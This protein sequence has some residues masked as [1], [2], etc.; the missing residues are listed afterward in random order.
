[1]ARKIP[2]K[3]ILELHAAHMSRN[4]IAVTR[5]ISK[6]SVSTVLHIAAEKGISYQDIRDMEEADVYRLFFPEK[7]AVEVLFRDPEYE[8]VHSELKKTG[9]TLKLLWE[10]YQ[11]MCRSEGATPMG[12]SKFCDGY[13]EFTIAKDCH[14]HHSQTPRQ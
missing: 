10:E 7:H 14:R 6:N 11:E 8:H 4:Q 1:M 3:L 13:G 9:V 5:S 2:V 12:Y